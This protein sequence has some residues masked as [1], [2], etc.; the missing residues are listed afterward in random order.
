MSNRTDAESAVL[1]Q[2]YDAVI[3]GTVEEEMLPLFGWRAATFSFQEGPVKERDAVQ[4]M[5]LRIMPVSL[6]LA[7]PVKVDVKVGKNWGELE[8]VEAAASGGG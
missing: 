8:E 3:A 4:E 2:M 6:E 7:V 1:K 5:V